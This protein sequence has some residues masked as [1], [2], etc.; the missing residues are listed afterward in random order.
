MSRI[1]QRQ[2]VLDVIK[3]WA[4]YH[5]AKPLYDASN[6]VIDRPMFGVDLGPLADAI[7]EAME[8]GRLGK[9]EPAIEIDREVMAI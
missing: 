7:V 5:G 3:R 6:S 2:C 8:A 9:I 4:E 1:H